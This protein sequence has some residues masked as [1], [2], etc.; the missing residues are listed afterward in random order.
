MGLCCQSTQDM[1]V[2]SGVETYVAQ[3]DIL[4][5]GR[6]DS[7]TLLDFLQQ[8]INKILEAGVLESTFARFGEG[9]SN[10]EG[11]DDVVGVL[12]GPAARDCRI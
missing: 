2:E 8:S 11:N 5:Q 1:E 3:A 9:C 10:G 12:G 7:R 4:N 6:V